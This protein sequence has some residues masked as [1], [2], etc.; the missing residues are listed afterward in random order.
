MTVADAD[1][2]AIRKAL[3]SGK[4]AFGFTPSMSKTVVPVIV[5]LAKEVM[6]N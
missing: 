6:C 4:K 3:E 2:A 1:E 5:R